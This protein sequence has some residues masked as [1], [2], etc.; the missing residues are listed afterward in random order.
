MDMLRI[1]SSPDEAI[2]Q[3]FISRVIIL[4]MRK[5]YGHTFQ[6]RPTN[7]NSPIL[8]CR[9]SWSHTNLATSAISSI[10]G[11]GRGTSSW[12]EILIECASVTILVNV[13]MST[14]VQEVVII[15]F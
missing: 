11:F 5:I 6:L 4:K 13:G 7:S 14:T 15:Y 12:V 1:S 10:P 2:R 3:Q 8:S 9:W